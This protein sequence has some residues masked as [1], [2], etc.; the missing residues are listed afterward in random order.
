M[1]SLGKGAQSSQ[2]FNRQ[3]SDPSADPFA[4]ASDLYHFSQ[5]A[6]EFV[7]QQLFGFS[8]LFVFWVFFYFV[9]GRIGYGGFCLV[10]FACLFLG[11]EFLFGC[12]LSK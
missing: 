7:V 2:F 8:F 10:L 11:F 4:P 1:W 6:S 3:G 5:K 12:I 9:W